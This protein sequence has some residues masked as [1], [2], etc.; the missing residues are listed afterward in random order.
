MSFLVR[1]GSVRYRLCVVR[2]LAVA[3]FV[4]EIHRRFGDRLY[5]PIGGSATACTITAGRGKN[6]PAHPLC[7]KL[8]V[9]MLFAEFAKG[10]KEKNKN[11]GETL[12]Q[13]K[14]IL[15]SL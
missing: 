13:R 15:S 14:P 9:L 10:K 3:P 11:Q 6:P 5:N 12:T 7:P 8:I 1:T 4:K 2:A